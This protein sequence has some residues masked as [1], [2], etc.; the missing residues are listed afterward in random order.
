[1]GSV[2]PGGSYVEKV[3]VAYTDN[4][5]YFGVE[6]CDDETEAQE[7]INDNTEFTFH[8]VVS[9]DDDGDVGAYKVK[10]T[11]VELEFDKWLAV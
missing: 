8:K 6:V 3:L 11:G 1:M 7:F 5:G 2:P 10:R 9:I 4:F